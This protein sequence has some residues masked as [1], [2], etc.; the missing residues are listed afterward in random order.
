M[1][2]PKGIKILLMIVVIMAVGCQGDF[3]QRYSGLRTDLEIVRELGGQWCAPKD[4]ASAEAYLFFAKTE[5]SNRNTKLAMAYLDYVKGHITT[6]KAKC[7]NCKVDLDFDGIRDL[8]DSDPYQAEDYDGWQDHD[9]IPD[10]DN[11]GDGFLDADDRCPNSPEDFDNW[12][13]DD[14]CPEIDNDFD[15]IPD[16]RDQCPMA[17]EDIDGW[18]DED[19]CPDP[20]NDF[21]GIPDGADACPNA[22][23]TYNNFLDDDGCPDF[24]PKRIKIIRL[25][26]NI[27]FIGSTLKLPNTAIAELNKF[28]ELCLENPELYI[29]IEG[30]TDRGGTADKLN[31]L[32]KERAEEIKRILIDF[33][34]DQGRITTFG[35]GKKEGKTNRT[36]YWVEFVIYQR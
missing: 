9:G 6:A 10:P 27:R 20:D 32:T 36:G 4:F 13:D 8:D 29:R 26:K 17:V 25:P 28:S 5:A 19:G 3:K 1:K 21:D 23:E 15:G 30:Y 35:F 34:L 31:T 7:T 16:G 22:P 18:Q 11:D 12:Q 14:G 24:L 33:G 2:G